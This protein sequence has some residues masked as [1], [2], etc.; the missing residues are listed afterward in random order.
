MGFIHDLKLIISKLE[1]TQKRLDW[2]EYFMSLA[3]IT[4]VRSSCNR[5]HVGC[6]L[7]KDSRILSTGYNGFI[8]KLPHLSIVRNNHEQATV[9]AEQNAI[10]DA[11]SRGISLKG[12]TAYITHYPCI[13]CA[14]MLLSINV[15]EIIY[16]NDYKN[17]PV[18]ESLFKQSTVNIKKINL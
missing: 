1:S 7:V 10:A 16:L 9:H 3:M 8:K 12:C 11:A 5:L 6:V 13:N 14:K 17:D 4:S 18:V 2:E 15:T